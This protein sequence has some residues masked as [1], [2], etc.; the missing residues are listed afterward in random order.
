MAGSQSYRQAMAKVA[1]LL[2]QN[3]PEEAEQ[4]LRNV[5]AA[6]PGNRTA[7]EIL[8]KIEQA[9][10][11]PDA[12]V[13]RPDDRLADQAAG[14]IV[15][16][17]PKQGVRL[18]QTPSAKLETRISM[19]M[20]VIWIIA[21]TVSGAAG[22]SLVGS[23][24]VEMFGVGGWL[25]FKTVFG[26]CIGAGQYLSLRAW[27]KPPGAWIFAGALSGM[28]GAMPALGIGVL[29]WEQFGLF[30]G[31]SSALALALL[32]G[33]ARFSL[34]WIPA[35]VLAGLAAGIAAPRLAA[36]ILGP[37][38]PILVTYAMT[39]GAGF[40]FVYGAVTALSLANVI[41]ALR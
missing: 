39:A 11:S 30:F 37:T 32:V 21:N 17:P 16:K 23:V 5:L 25:F 3:R 33:T 12:S 19:S 4:I 29:T 36:A 31:I 40:G 13:P 22:E 27:L 1:E 35:S 18:R 14:H 26:A 28:L 20:I 9:T 8:H 2:Q 41:R 24:G 15:G 38:D 10:A 7:A 6:E 34:T